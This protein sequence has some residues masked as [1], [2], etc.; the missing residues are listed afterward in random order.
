VEARGVLLRDGHAPS[1]G[2]V[3]DYATA[4]LTLANGVHARIACSWNLSA[5]AD[6][7]IEATFYGTATGAAMRNEG[8]SFFDFS[9]ELFRGRDREQLASP[10]D[11]WGGRA[12]VE[13]LEKL[14]AGERFAGR[15]SGLLETARVLDRLYG[16]S[17]S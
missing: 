4:E 10:P 15:T 7:V 6:A 14:T 1:A 11:D 13:W 5:G 2:E 12:A 16:R 8:G 3:E 9:A 17:G